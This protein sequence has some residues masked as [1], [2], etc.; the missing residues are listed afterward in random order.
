MLPRTPKKQAAKGC[1]V[2]RKRCPLTRCP[3]AHDPLCVRGACWP[4]I[5]PE[6]GNWPTDDRHPLTEPADTPLSGAVT[7]AGK[8][9]L[10]AE[11]IRT[12]RGG[13]AVR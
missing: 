7:A 1:Q 10:L 6:S 4:V 12:A 2:S 8:E 5:V 3:P 11:I 9:T 13:I